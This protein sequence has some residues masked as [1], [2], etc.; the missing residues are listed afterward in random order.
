MRAA[1]AEVLGSEP[2]PNLSD[3]LFHDGSLTIQGHAAN[4][5]R[6]RRA[7]RLPRK[8]EGPALSLSA[9]L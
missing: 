4:P 2:K 8:R 9:N 1:S 6:N 3:E 7:S 5:D